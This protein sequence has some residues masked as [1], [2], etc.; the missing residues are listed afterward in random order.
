MAESHHTDLDAQARPGD[1]MKVLVVYQS[2]QSELIRALEREGH[3]VLVVH[4][5]ERPI[6]FLSVFRPEVIVV[7]APQAAS[8]CQALREVAPCVSLIAVVPGARPEDRVAA[9][10]AGADDSLSAPVHRAELIARVRASR[11]RASTP[12]CGSRPKT[13]PAGDEGSRGNPEPAPC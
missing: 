2:W 10:E 3:D 6:R 13:S 8:I 11:R 5:A 12:G 9:L 1:P 7:A 4:P